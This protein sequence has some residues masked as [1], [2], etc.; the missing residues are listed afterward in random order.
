MR[1]MLL[2]ALAGTLLLARP[3]AA[4]ETIVFAHL[5]PETSRQQKA[6]LAASAY[7]PLG[8]ASAP[9]NFR[10]YAHWQHFRDSKLFREL[11]AGYEA[12]TGN[13]VL[14]HSYYG[15]RHVTANKPI[16]TPADLAGLKIRV[17]NSPSYIQLFRSLGATPI[18]LPFSEVY[19]ALKNKAVDAEEMVTM[20]AKLS[21][22]VRG[23]EE[24]LR[25]GLKVKGV[26]FVEPDRT[27]FVAALGPLLRG[28][29]FPW[30]GKIYQAVQDIP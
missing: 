11:A 29:K 7:P 14:A 20:A 19:D 2:A 16:N 21:D 28:D 30:S 27:K 8:I 13:F 17:P 15:A 1:R 18:P 6:L 5:F 3:A 10:D 26:T 22:A 25:A 9:Y 12:S 23:D 24:S 4:V